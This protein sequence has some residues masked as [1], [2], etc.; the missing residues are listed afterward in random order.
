M[1]SCLFEVLPESPVL[2]AVLQ[3]LNLFPINTLVLLNLRY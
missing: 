1:D 2:K 3:T